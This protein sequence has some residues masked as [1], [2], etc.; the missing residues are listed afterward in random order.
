MKK[1]NNNRISLI[2]KQTCFL[3]LSMLLSTSNAFSCTRP[4]ASIGYEGPTS[5][6]TI[7]GDSTDQSWPGKFT[8]P[9]TLE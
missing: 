2:G 5:D 6:P 4:A 1:H 8:V 3:F 9:K 7:M